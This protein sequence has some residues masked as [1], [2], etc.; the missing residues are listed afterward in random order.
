MT[1]QEKFLDA[2]ERC[3]SAYTAGGTTGYAPLYVGVACDYGHEYHFFKRIYDDGDLEGDDA[4]IA[5]LLLAY[6]WEDMQ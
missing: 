3:F 1:T 2:A 4:V 5:I 6:A